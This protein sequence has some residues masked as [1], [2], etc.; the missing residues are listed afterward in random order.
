MYAGRALGLAFG[1]LEDLQAKLTGARGL[2]EAAQALL[3]EPAD[4]AQVMAL[5]ELRAKAQGEPIAIKELEDIDKRL[6]ALAWNARVRTEFASCLT[7]GMLFPHT[8]CSS[9]T[10]LLWSLLSVLTRVAGPRPP[11]L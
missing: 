1:Q 11:T 2:S 6:A 7:T 9:E 8:A 5:R 4:E 3:R 10:P